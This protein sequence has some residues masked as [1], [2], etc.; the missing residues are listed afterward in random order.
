MDPPSQDGIFTSMATERAMK[1]L[2]GAM[3]AAALLGLSGCSANHHSIFRHQ[4]VATNPTVTL[5]DAKQRAIL[6]AGPKKIGSDNEVTR[7]CAE[8][9]PDVFAVI[10]Q[11]LSGGASFGRS[12]DPKTV[13]AALNAAFSS[14]EQGSTIPRTQTSNVL[15]EVMFRTCERYLNGGINGAEL[16]LQAA[17]DQRLIVSILAIEGLTGAVS[18]RPVV[19]GA[20]AAGSSGSSGA[21]AAIRL[22]DQNKVIQQKANAVGKKQAA[23]DDLNG[24]EKDCESIAKAVADKKEADLSQALKDKRPKCEAAT[25]ELDT[26]KKEKAEADAHYKAMASAASGGGIPVAVGGTLMQ[27]V[28]NGGSDNNRP[29]D[30][31]QVTAAV[32]DIVFGTFNQDEFLFLCLKSLGDDALKDMRL[33]C[34]EYVRSQ[35]DLERARNQETA[36]RINAAKE[37]IQLR[38]EVLFNQFWARV[39]VGDQLDAAKLEA[40]R[41]NITAADWPKCFAGAKSKSEVRSC[42]MSGDVVAQVKRELAAGRSSNGGS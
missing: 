25:A 11:A 31:S 23:F 15:R 38:S 14:S 8:P 32:K 26:A 9:S 22:D 20:S 17:R 10:A 28:A 4:Q 2:L 24:K 27:P 21:D 35:V 1:G 33:S 16:S 19:I 30:M 37:G 42:F 34:L 29:S 40:V 13:E 6:S 12:S 7:F 5:V 39:S 41:K 36:A 3:A 18:F